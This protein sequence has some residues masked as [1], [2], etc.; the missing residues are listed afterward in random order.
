MPLPATLARLAGLAAEKLRALADDFR[1]ADRFFKLRAGVVA[2]WALVSVATVFGACPSAGPSNGLGAEVSIL[3]ADPVPGEQ[4]P[5]EGQIVGSAKIMI[6][7][8]SDD[9]WTDVVLKLDGAW[10]YEQAT[11]RPRDYVVLLVSQFRQDGVPPPP[12]HRP[13]TLEVRCRQGRHR[14]ELR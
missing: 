1:R 7:N 5:G 9:I 2:A 6:R 12:D 13:R 3:K 10:R 4:A 8:E 11:I 14:F